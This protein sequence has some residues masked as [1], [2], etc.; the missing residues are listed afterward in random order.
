[1]IYTVN[2]R[3]GIGCLINGSET[4]VHLNDTP[5]CIVVR[6][7]PYI[8]ILHN[9]MGYSVHVVQSSR[10]FIT[11]CVMYGTARRR[12]M[13]SRAAHFLAEPKSTLLKE[14]LC[15]IHGFAEYL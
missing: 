10:Q 14:Q 9:D 12:L 6:T 7:E 8:I 13:I 5:L 11:G 1:M 2:Y 3:L 15:F 4:V